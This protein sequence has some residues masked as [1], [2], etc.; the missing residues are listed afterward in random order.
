MGPAD[1]MLFGMNS[2]QKAH[3]NRDLVGLPAQK[4]Q[5]PTSFSSGYFCADQQNA[6]I[7]S[8]LLRDVIKTATCSM[9]YWYE[10]VTEL[11]PVV[12]HLHK[13]TDWHDR[14]DRRNPARNMPYG[15][16]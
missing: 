1:R 14:S 15:V 12:R 6:H 16:G 13:V 4:R 10:K 9:Q 3:L 11:L 5:S 7:C 8:N 2:E